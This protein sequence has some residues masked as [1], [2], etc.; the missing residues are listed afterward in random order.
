[1][2]TLAPLDDD[3]DDDDDRWVLYGLQSRSVESVVKKRFCPC[4]EWT[5]GHLIHFLGWSLW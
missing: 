4:R 3:D 2:W 5:P 1:M